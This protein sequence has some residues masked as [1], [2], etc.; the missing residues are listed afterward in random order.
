VTKYKSADFRQI[1]PN[2][3]FLS[4]RRKG[5]ENGGDTF[6]IVTFTDER[7]NTCKKELELLHLPE[8]FSRQCLVII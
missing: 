6:V 4:S 2:L 1:L 3:A 8:F 7:L 5:Q